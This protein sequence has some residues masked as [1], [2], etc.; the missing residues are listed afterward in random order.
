M[1][2]TL[3][4]N[5]PVI[6]ARRHMEETGRMYGDAIERIASGKRINKSGDD[7]A[8]LAI[9][10]A[11]EGKIRSIAQ[12]RRNAKE[13]LSLMQVAEGGMNEVS[14][15]L[16]RMRELAI[17][18]ASDTIGD[19]ER[20]MLELENQQLKKEIDR[21][22]N[23]TE[24]FGTSLLN[25]EGKEFTFQIGPDN[26]ENNRVTYST[27]KLDLRASTLGVDG[28]SL[29]DE[30]SALDALGSVDEAI[31]KLNVPR[32]EAGAMQTR[33]NSII[34]N[35][36]I[37][38][39]N[40]IQARSRIIDADLAAE[41]AKATQAAVLQKAGAAVIAQANLMPHLALKLLE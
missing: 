19:S 30:D 18:G 38:E 40:M 15:L 16:V 12:A 14:N 7:A 21:L 29:S 25:G 31:T 10:T 3:L 22:A 20:S 32:S 36:S 4:S 33:F 37:Y 35:L 9:S 28:V 39:E 13:A 5:L 8:G 6:N 17:Q 24:Y 27:D 11:M 26:N 34:N 23:A 41:T 1:A 2:I